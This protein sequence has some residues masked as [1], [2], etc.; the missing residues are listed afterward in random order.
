MTKGIG[1]YALMGLAGDLYA[2]QHPD[3]RCDKRYFITKLS[4]FITDIDWTSAGP[5]NGLGGEGGAKSALQH[6]RMVRAHKNVKVVAV[7][8]YKHSAH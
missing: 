4:E 1:V 6:I 3:Q 7:A 5:L 2:E 8:E